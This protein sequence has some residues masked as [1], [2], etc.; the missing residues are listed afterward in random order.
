[1]LKSTID[2]LKLDKTSIMT[3]LNSSKNSNDDFYRK[4]DNIMKSHREKQTAKMKHFSTSAPIPG[5]LMSDYLKR[6]VNENNSGDK[7]QPTKSSPS[8]QVEKPVPRPIIVKVEPVSESEETSS[9]P[10]EPV[11]RRQSSSS[12][13]ELLPVPEQ[14]KSARLRQKS[15]VNYNSN[16]D[17]KLIRKLRDPKNRVPYR[18]AGF[19]MPIIAAPQSKFSSSSDLPT[20]KIRAEKRKVKLSV[21]ADPAPK[22]RRGRQPKTALRDEQHDGKVKIPLEVLNEDV[23]K[24]EDDISA[25]LSAGR[26]M[27]KFD[28]PVTMFQEFDMKHL[29]LTF[30]SDKGDPPSKSQP[31]PSC[32]RAA[33]K[34]LAHPGDITD[35]EEADMEIDEN[36][37]PSTSLGAA[38]EVS[39][40]VD[41]Q[42]LQLSAVKKV[43]NSRRKSKTP[44]RCQLWNVKKLARRGGFADEI[45]IQIGT[46]VERVE[47]QMTTKSTGD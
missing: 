14:V 17:D 38:G 4:I 43:R 23:L 33:T 32:Q 19:V 27:I 3:K 6:L 40:E 15:R 18:K 39:S 20:K 22:K 24:T 8:D 45:D 1:M 11:N 10:E 28:F 13:N 47:A 16:D 35:T 30:E 46:A 25:T 34:K 21:A 31:S 12:I 26:T 5:E 36:C 7:S 29:K 37:V 44:T 42:H 41:V 9:T 2:R